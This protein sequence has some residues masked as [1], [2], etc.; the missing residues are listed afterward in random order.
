MGNAEGLVKFCRAVQKRC[1]IGSYINPT[2][3]ATAGYESEVRRKEKHN[4]YF[5]LHLLD[6]FT[7]YQMN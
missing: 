6:K 5:Q 4:R 7:K 1:P 3:G 2:A